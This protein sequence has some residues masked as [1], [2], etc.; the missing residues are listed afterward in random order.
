MGAAAK[1]AQC[2]GGVALR[3]P[4]A[5][6]QTAQ[7]RWRLAAD[8][9]ASKRPAAWKRGARRRR[10]SGLS[11]TWGAR[12]GEAR[13]LS[14]SAMGAS[15]LGI[16]CVQRSSYPA[17]FSATTSHPV[18]APYQADD[19]VGVLAVG[20]VGVGQPPAWAVGC[21]CEGRDAGV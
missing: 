16:V 6:P 13:R 14:R 20:D 11:G 21:E 12:A 1:P 8:P 3:R 15:R 9:I 4:N 10:K 2:R 7:T 18:C 17:D 19:L 5:T